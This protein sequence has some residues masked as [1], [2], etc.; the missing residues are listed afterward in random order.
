[1]TEISYSKYE[2]I[3]KGRISALN[4]KTKSK[5]STGTTRRRKGSRLT[6]KKKSNKVRVG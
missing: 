5:E 3:P 6:Q 4:Y 1:M 2:N